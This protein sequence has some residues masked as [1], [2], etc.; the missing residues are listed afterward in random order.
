LEVQDVLDLSWSVRALV[1]SAL[2]RLL[3][4]EAADILAAIEE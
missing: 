1:A 3:L 4:P 2:V